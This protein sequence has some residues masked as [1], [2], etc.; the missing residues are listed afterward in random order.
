MAEELGLGLFQP[1]RIRDV[2]ADRRIR[3]LRPDLLVAVAYG[4]ILPMS[5]LAVPRLG[6]LNLHA[7]LLPRHRGPAP[8]AWALLSGDLETGVTIIQMEAE[9]DT[10]PII[11]QRRL[12]IGPQ[13]TANTLEARLAEAGAALLVETL[14][15]LARRA[16]APLPQPAE[17]VTYAPRLRSEDGRLNLDMSAKEIDRRVRALSPSPGCWISLGT[18]A[19][20]VLRGR[21]AGEDEPPGGL[22]LQTRDGVYVVEE[23]QVPG[24]RPVSAAAYLRGR[25]R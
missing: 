15:A 10:G 8:I 18:G 21:V 23:V 22:A 1:A 6:A 11:A 12:S 5:L 14:P 4:Q 2:E 25:R 16:V 17:G 24:R 9:V 20:K 7:S 3:S 19:V 13:E